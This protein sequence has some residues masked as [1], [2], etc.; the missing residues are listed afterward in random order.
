[1]ALFIF[2]LLCL[3]SVLVGTGTLYLLGFRKEDGPV[4]IASPLIALCVWSL[5]FGIGVSIK[6]PVRVLTYLTWGISLLLC[7]IAFRFY[8]YPKLFLPIIV[9]VVVALFISFPYVV[10]GFSDY[11]G[12]PFADGWSYIAFGQYLW[13]YPRCIE[14]GLAPLYQYAAHLCHTRFIA[15]SLLGFISPLT[16]SPGDTQAASGYF[17][18]WAFFVY[19]S[20]CMFFIQKRKSQLLSWVY[21]FICVVTGWLFTITISNNYDQ[22]LAIGFLP[23]IAGFFEFLDW[24]KMRWGIL[25]AIVLSSVVYIYP[26][27]TPFVFLSASFLLIHQVLKHRVYF[28]S[29][30]KVGGISIF[31]FA[32]LISTYFMTWFDFMRSQI[33]SVQAAVRPGELIAS[34]LLDK[35][36]W[37]LAVWG[38]GGDINTVDWL[39]KVCA[40]LFLILSILGFIVLVKN[41]NW[42][43]I[44]VQIL[45]S[46]FV[47]Y[48]IQVQ[49]YSYGA[50]KIITLLWWLV[51]YTIILAFQWLQSKNYPRFIPVLSNGLSLLTIITVA[52]VNLGQ[53]IGFDR[54]LIN[55]NIAPYKELM[56]IQP[57][58]NYSPVGISVTDPIANLWAMYYLRGATTYFFS[59]EAYPNQPHVLPFMFR[60]QQVDV[61]EIKYLLTDRTGFR[62]EEASKV[63]HNSVYSLWKIKN[64]PFFDAEI[65]NPNGVDLANNKEFYWLDN[66]KTRVDIQSSFAGSI[67]IVGDFSMGPSLPDLEK[68]NLVLTSMVNG[69]SQSLMFI[70]RPGQNTIEI[71]VRKGKNEFEISVLDEPTVFSLPNGDP[72]VLLLSL[73][74][75]QF[76]FQNESK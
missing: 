72:R 35:N 40:L 76:R 53:W 24:S 45:L 59:Y 71:P 37:W 48:F 68:R 21:V 9:P 10:H 30:A 22:A 69:E 6:V 55:S 52:Y 4:F 62:P 3:V 56:L 65:L 7:L 49:K 13:E 33:S 5:I 1:V 42:G 29:L 2:A 66:R 20:A 14:G 18:P 74:N 23:A 38:L 16:G 8:R 44:A 67:A 27:I 36:Y 61:S 19:G 73:Q 17:F 46:A 50:Y 70:V 43:L 51:A 60:S 54:E 58:V 32:L 15:S 57:I 39:R 25:L 47:A 75:I 26:E 12:S 11:T 64:F 28:V 41:K 31:V 63:W 34:E